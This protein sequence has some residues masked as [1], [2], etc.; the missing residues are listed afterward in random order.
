MLPEGNMIEV[1]DL[2]NINQLSYL[3]CSEDN[4][5]MLKL[6]CSWHT[7]RAEKQGILASSTLP[8]E[9]GLVMS[10]L[11]AVS[12]A[13][14]RYAPAQWIPS[15]YEHYLL[16]CWQFHS[17]SASLGNRSRLWELFWQR[18]SLR[19]FALIV[20]TFCMKKF[21]EAIS[22]SSLPERNCF[23]PKSNLMLLP[24]HRTA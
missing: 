20:F 8:D 23:S 10:P 9:A 13:H 15:I 16:Q 24:V 21:G 19:H 22:C 17:C 12:E 4:L 6:Y 2:S 18:E 3:N 7:P 14:R 11:R 1:L 5:K